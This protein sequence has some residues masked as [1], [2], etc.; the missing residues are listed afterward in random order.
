MLEVLVFG[1]RAN[2]GEGVL[3]QGL[4]CLKGIARDAGMQALVGTGRPGWIR[5][6]PVSRYRNVWEI[7][8]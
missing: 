4:Q 5:K 7:D 6:L 3:E 8:L 2:R 1:C